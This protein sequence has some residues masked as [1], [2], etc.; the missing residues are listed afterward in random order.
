MFILLKCIMFIFINLPF[1]IIPGKYSRLHRELTEGTWV[2]TWLCFT[3]SLPVLILYLYLSCPPLF[4]AVT[5]AGKCGLLLHAAH[6]SPQVRL[7]EKCGRLPK[8]GIGGKRFEPNMKG[9]GFYRCVVDV[10]RLCCCPVCVCVCVCVCVSLRCW[11]IIASL[12]KC[13]S[14]R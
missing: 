4:D 7:M 13:G 5:S 12:M 6:T 14:G 10:F 8:G 9:Q 3:Y 2:P 11:N 1:V